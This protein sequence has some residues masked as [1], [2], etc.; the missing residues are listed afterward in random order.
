MTERTSPGRAALRD[1]RSEGDSGGGAAVQPQVREL[2][3]QGL[4]QQASR[5]AR[6]DSL[7]SL[8]STR[9]TVLAG[10]VAPILGG[11][12]LGSALLLRAVRR[13][14]GSPEARYHAAR[15][16]LE[17][18]GPIVAWTRMREWGQDL[19][20]QAP[21]ALRAAWLALRGVVAGR[22]RDFEA[23]GVLLRA[24]EAVAPGRARTQVAWAEVL[25]EQDRRAPALDAAREALRRCPWYTPAVQTAA[26]L[27][28]TLGRGEEACDLLRAAVTATE[29]SRLL[30]QLASHLSEQRL[31]HECLECLRRLEAGA[32]LL[33]RGG[34]DWL[35]SLR[36]WALHELGELDPE[37]PRTDRGQPEG[38]RVM[39]PVPF[40][41]QDRFTC[42]PATLSELAAYWGRPFD[43]ATV[44][45]A[46]CYH[47]TPRH[48][49]RAWAA[50]HGWAVREFR[51]T[52][53]STRAVLDR[54]IPFALVTQSAMS[55]HDQ[56]VVGYDE[57]RGTL[58]IR[59]PSRPF[60]VEV[61]A[62][63]FLDGQRW[64][65]PRATIL[66]PPF[67]IPRLSGLDLPDGEAYDDLHELEQA[68][69]EHCRDEA[70]T[71]ARR[72]AER[73]PRNRLNV[74]ATL[75][76]AQY[77]SDD[78]T[79]L[80]CVE[81]LLGA[82]PGTPAL[83]LWRLQ[84]LR[85]LAH[86]TAR[87]KAAAAACRRHPRELALQSHLAFELSLQPGQ[88]EK[89]RRV[90]R[91]V[92]R[93]GLWPTGA[94][95]LLTLANLSGGEGRSQYVRALLGLA[96]HLEDLQE[97][98]ARAYFSRAHAERRTEE[99]LEFLGARFAAY[100]AQSG[101]P[102][103]TLFEALEMAGKASE[104]LAVLGA[105]MRLRPHDADL[106]LFAARAHA[107][108]GTLERAEK[109]LAASS[110]RTHRT[111]WLRAAAVVALRRDDR[112]GSLNLWREVLAV[113]PAAVDA[114]RAV[115]DL[116]RA[117]GK[118]SAAVAHLRALRHRFPQHH[119]LTELSEAS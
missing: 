49:A 12:R 85:K 57:R 116:L 38:R 14:P 83:E 118:T 92:L 63:S 9:A 73:E 40:I 29:D 102:A 119:A 32:P 96:A 115:A 64:C 8:G 30:Q 21:R 93:G 54:G 6:F 77:D 59:C 22:F 25:I 114:H 103:Q 39:L 100:G 80:Q 48:R 94:L 101:D 84:A 70:G 107:E 65:G 2:L 98:L 91:P 42:S 34:R 108:R 43:Q 56:A 53:E 46:I 3:A 37:R 26:H 95:N 18:Q 35:R 51:A 28:L 74:W 76:L 111:Q 11:D 33:D 79:Q 1:S 17:R 52:W 109:L 99:G 72:M 110:G 106:R 62:Q 68:L 67:E 10:R 4:R 75:R 117:M 55:A 105:A 60:V 23:A 66:L 89:A 69:S 19:G 81:A 113:E 24:A 16:L 31:F 87:A 88:K 7:R 58:S 13:D 44:A 50:E 36:S 90:L 104:G 71:F 15:V 45:E 78:S 5:L 61:E 47:G 41:P 20:W 97:G 112:P 82:F 27:L 86:P